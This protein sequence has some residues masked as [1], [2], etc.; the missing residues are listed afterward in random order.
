MGKFDCCICKTWTSKR[1]TNTKNWEVYFA[2]CFGDNASSRKGVICESCRRDICSYRSD[3]NQTFEHKLD[4]SLRNNTPKVV[5]RS[6]TFSQSCKER[7]HPD[8]RRLINLS[9]EIWIEILKFLDAKDILQF[10]KVCTTARDLSFDSVLWKR[11]YI[12]D[13]GAILPTA[14]DFG[15]HWRSVVLLIKGSEE[16]NNIK[17]IKEKLHLLHDKLQ[18]TEKDNK[19]GLKTI[20]NLQKIINHLSSSDSDSQVTP[21]EEKTFRN[22]LK[23][24]MASSS[25]GLIEAKNP[26]R[27]SVMLQSVKTS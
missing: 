16:H 13:Y 4:T 7:F 27:R 9:H 25:S 6:H 17:A 2:G 11:L 15:A 5:I 8:M 14:F 19:K 12:L 26:R 21:L 24:K 23:K 22:I 3:N 1:F 20:Q 18:E 10:G